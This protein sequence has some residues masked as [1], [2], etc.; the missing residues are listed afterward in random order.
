MARKAKKGKGLPTLPRVKGPE[1]VAAFRP[2]TQ[3]IS[4]AAVNKHLDDK[5][6]LKQRYDRKVAQK[7]Y[8]TMLRAY[9]HTRD[10]R[11]LQTARQDLFGG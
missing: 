7:L 6:K 2:L 3:G 11:T 4:Q 9:Q 5:T 8:D 10:P 1:R